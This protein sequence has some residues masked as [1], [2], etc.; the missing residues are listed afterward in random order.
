MWSWQTT[1]A[2]GGHATDGCTQPAVQCEHVGTCT[3]T[4]TMLYSLYGQDMIRSGPTWCSTS[5]C[6][7]GLTRAAGSQTHTDAHAMKGAWGKQW[8]ASKTRPIL[9]ELP[10]G[11]MTLAW[12]AKLTHWLT[13]KGSYI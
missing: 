13:R 2:T 9:T 7:A 8:P 11:P 12:P 6:A 1:G 3:K 4:G 10:T 5:R